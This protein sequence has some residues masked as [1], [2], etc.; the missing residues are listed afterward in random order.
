M[1]KWALGKIG[2]V[3]MLRNSMAERKMRC[4]GHIVWT[5]LRK[6]L[7]KE[8]WKASGEGADQQR[9]GSRI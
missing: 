7:C 9:P 6:E 1:N 8:R 3:L 2:S 4:I 5:V